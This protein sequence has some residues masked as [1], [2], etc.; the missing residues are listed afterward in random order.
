MRKISLK[1]RCIGCTILQ[2]VLAVCKKLSYLRFYF[3]RKLTFR[4][5]SS[6]FR[7]KICFYILFAFLQSQFR[8]F[9]I[10]F[11]IFAHLCNEVDEGDFLPSFGNM[12]HPRLVLSYSWAK[13]SVT[14]SRTSL[15][16]NCSIWVSL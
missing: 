8:F 14:A 5:Y 13:A 9:V 6:F 15:S 7:L 12:T 10:F 4:F 11:S 2:K 16:V 3:Y 1:T